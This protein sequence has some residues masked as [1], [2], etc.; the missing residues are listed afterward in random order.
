MAPARRPAYRVLIATHENPGGDAVG[1]MS[2][3]A[4]ALSGL[5][6]QVRTY[7]H[8]DSTIPHEVSFLN[9]N[10]L[11]RTVDP[12]SLQGWSLLALDC[13][14]ERRI[15]PGFDALLEAAD[16]VIDVDHHHD[17]SR[18]GTVNLI[19]GGAPSTAEI[20]ARIFDEL[21]VEITPPIAEA[22]YVVLVTDPGRFQ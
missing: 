17:N 21:G 19:D 8:A 2:A 14:N 18:F 5:G 15:G 16:S 4:M 1:S 10:S 6:K 12:A 3:A 9:T 11:E 7:I 20:L 13:G 22:L